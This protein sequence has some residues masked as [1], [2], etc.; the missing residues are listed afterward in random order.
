[1][2]TQG[3]THG[4]CGIGTYAGSI[5]QG[6][7]GGWRAC[8]SGTTLVGGGSLSDAAGA[9]GNG[10]SLV[11]GGSQLDAAG[12]CVS[13]AADASVAQPSK[14]SLSACR[15]LRFLRVLAFS[16]FLLRRAY[17]CKRYDWISLG[18]AGGEEPWTSLA[19]GGSQ[20]DAAGDCGN[21]TSLA[22]GG[23]VL[24]AAGASVSV[25]AGVSVS[26]PSV[27]DAAGGPS[28]DWGFLRTRLAR[29]LPRLMTL[30]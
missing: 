19:G 4:H 27:L 7:A 6:A 16:H 8:G 22:G 30:R 17:T 26:L 23:S 18:D 29:C 14:R 28:G 20:L 9:F 24:E 21:S 3:R 12:A 10:T 2:T 11:G 13:E 15:F 1:M 5:L 25:A